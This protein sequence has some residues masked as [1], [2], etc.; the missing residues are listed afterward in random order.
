LKLRERLSIESNGE[1]MKVWY[2]AC[3]GKHIRYGSAIAKR[4]RNLG[5]EV[6]LTTRKHP[7]TL[8]LAKSLK[9]DFT[10]VG[11][12]D[13]TSLFTRLEASARRV[14]ELSKLLKGNVPDIAV[15]S[16]SV[17][18]G[19]VAFGLGIPTILTSDT[20]HAMAVN[21]LTIPFAS[22]LVISEVIPKRLFRKYGRPEIIHFKGV[23]EVAWIRSLK[24]SKGLEVK[25]PLIVVRQMETAAAYALGKPDVTEEIALRLVKLGTVLFLHRYRKLQREG[26]LCFDE[27]VDSAAL[28]GNADLVVGVGGTLAREAAL[29]GV[30]SIVV[31]RFGRRYDYVNDYLFEKGFPLFITDPSKVLATAKRYLRKRWNVKERLAE[32]ENPV[33]VIAKLITEKHFSKIS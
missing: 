14:L 20:P 28:V 13:P 17:E 29:Q 9:E 1:R 2:D 25:R 7:D 4:L 11:E 3:T 19:R 30:P 23:D 24:P 21:K 10:P 22:T 18:L 12:Y 6:I 31:A 8:K 15:S 27:F 33:D 26:L 32:L 5:H 16:Q